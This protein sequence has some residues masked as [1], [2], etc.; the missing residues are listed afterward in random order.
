VTPRP[1]RSGRFSL[2]PRRIAGYGVRVQATVLLPPAR[3][4]R[5]PQFGYAPRVP[6]DLRFLCDEM[7]GRL[8]RYLRAAGYDT[9]L[10]T[11]GA[12][13][14]ELLAAARHE[15]RTF[16]TCDRRI[17][18]HKA[19][20]EVALILPRGTIDE[21]AHALAQ[22]VPIDWLHRP[23][24]RCLVDNAPLVAG[25]GVSR[26]APPP[27]VAGAEVRSCP[28]CGRL[29]WAGSHHRRMRARLAAWSDGRAASA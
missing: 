24:S 28:E 15:R 1:D 21:L 27:D 9:A 5:T 2:V 22:R 10:A 25:V 26:R 29:Y 4:R 8:A 14:R 6:G 12:P 16:V 23:F 18:L 17:A 13:D 7:L 19:A 20:T 3:E 11:G